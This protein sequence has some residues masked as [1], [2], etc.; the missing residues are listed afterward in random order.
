MPAIGPPRPLRRQ[1]PARRRPYRYTKTKGGKSGWR[2]RL[3]LAAGF[4][5]VV[6]ILWAVI[7]R[8]TAPVSNTNLTHF[9]AIVVLG[10]HADSDGNPTP[11]MLDRVSEGVHEYERG[12]A[13]RILFTGAAI[14]NRF[15]EADVMARAA[16]AEGIPSSAI[17]VEPNAR[18][19]IQNACIST[20]ILTQRG[21]RSAEVVTSGYHVP[22]AGLIFSH[23]PIEWR[24]RAA[25]Y[26]GSKIDD[27]LEVLKTVRYVVYASHTESCE[28]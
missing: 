4:C 22:R 23:M 3:L 11:E 9:D 27:L 20:R 6:V 26:A 10:T 12:V 7:A 28:L 17:I 24:T 14:R 1:K 18:D 16:E 15:V 8:G 25:P 2:I 5:V 13:P 21:W 19:T